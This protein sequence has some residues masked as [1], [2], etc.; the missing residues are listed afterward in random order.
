[1]NPNDK[2]KTFLEE[3]SD[4]Q[5]VDISSLKLKKHLSPELWENN[6]LKPD[7]ADVLY[8]IAKE[9]FETLALDAAIQLKD[10]TLTGSLATYNWSDLSDVDL[11]L[12]ID[13]NKLKER[14]SM[15]DYFKEKGRN[16]N[17][18]HKI[19]I[20]GYEVEVYIQ[21][22]NEPHYA[23]GIYSILNERWLKEPSR[24]RAEIDY[25]TIKRKAA[26]KMDAIDAVYDAYAEKEFKV[27]L[28]A[29]RSLMDRIRRYRRAGLKT[30]GISSVENLVFKV[31]RRN[32]YLRKLS[33]L[34]ILAYDQ[35]M[36]VNGG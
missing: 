3:L 29:A 12:L 26:E 19:L 1:M 10:V 35:L 11:H 4:P 25:E 9:F 33:S 18:T 23:N 2:W 21:D 20:K 30:D 13:F 36:S 34:K 32:D 24:W 17:N 28:Q 16:W 22:A 5:F 15:E 6:K 7:I 31:L 27:A 14:A 8:R